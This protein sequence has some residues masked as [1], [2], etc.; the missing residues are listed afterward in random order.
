M[1]VFFL[2]L[3]C[4]LPILNNAQDSEVKAH[5]ETSYNHHEDALKEIKLALSKL[6]E[7]DN[8]HSIDLMVRIASEA[9]S[10]ISRAARMIGYARDNA[11]EAAEEASECSTAEEHASD[12]EGYFYD[13]QRKLISATRDLPGRNKDLDLTKQAIA[14]AITNINHAVKRMNDAVTQLSATLEALKDCDEN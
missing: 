10:Y 8:T 1:K 4:S 5:V 3:I 12:A 9:N 6:E 13:A 2:L 7:C 14:D 11:S